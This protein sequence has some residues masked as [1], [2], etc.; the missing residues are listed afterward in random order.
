MTR[1]ITFRTHGSPPGARRRPPVAV[2]PFP[3]G[4]TLG[5]AR[6]SCG[7]IS[8]PAPRQRG[9]PRR[10]RPSRR[11]RPGGSPVF[12]NIGAFQRRTQDQ[13]AQCSRATDG[14]RPAMG[15]VR[16]FSD[17]RRR[18]RRLDRG[19]GDGLRSEHQAQARRNPRRPGPSTARAGARLPHAASREDAGVR[20]R[21][22]SAA[23]RGTARARRCVRR[24]GDESR[25]SARSWRSTVPAMAARSQRSRAGC[26]DTA[27]ALKSESGSRGWSA[28]SRGRSRCGSRRPRTTRSPGG[29]TVATCG[30]RCAATSRCAT[31]CSGC[32]RSPG[33]SGSSSPSRVSGTS[34]S[35]PARRRTCCAPSVAK[36]SAARDGTS[37]GCTSSSRSSPRSSYAPTAAARGTRSPARRSS[38]CFES[39]M[40]SGS[41]S[42][43]TPSASKQ[44]S[45][46]RPAPA[47]RSGSSSPTGSSPSSAT[48]SA[49][50]C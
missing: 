48:P 28:S 10:A 39:S 23:A 47:T 25:S 16:A 43:S 15:A 4:L 18:E 14:K 37:R 41:P 22:A 6:A 36:A 33:A 30:A 5:I 9:P 44:E 27:P 13:C 21:R 19:A 31:A 26:G 49:G 3:A 7:P 35:P 24:R 20:A 1:D 29:G 42:S 50:R 12:Q 8:G 17:E 38:E 11:E 46:P 32:W 40:A 45:A 2:T 34:T